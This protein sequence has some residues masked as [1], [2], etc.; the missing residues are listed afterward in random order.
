MQTSKNYRLSFIIIFVII[1]V[2]NVTLHAQ[3]TIGS[4]VPP[5]DSALLDLKEN[6]IGTSTKGLLLPRVELV[7]LNDNTP[8]SAHVRGMLVYNT[9]DVDTDIFEGCYYNDGTQ[10]IRVGA[11]AGSITI[12]DV[13]LTDLWQAPSGSG[14]DITKQEFR[15][16]GKAVNFIIKLERTGA[17]INVW[18]TAHNF[19]KI[20]EIPTGTNKDTYKPF[21][22]TAVTSEGNMNI[23]CLV[24]FPERS[25]STMAECE[26]DFE[27]NIYI[28]NVRESI[29][30]FMNKGTIATNDVIVV[31][32]SYFIK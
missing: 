31:S 22:S 25:I 3:V 20:A 17:D 26:I 1:L 7:A 10:W 4:D 14:W 27:G 21:A 5:D 23:S 32:G 9:A 29:G 18:N 15:G 6:S 13:G 12:P 24:N 19:Q 28:Q 8:L 16:Y 2:G 30:T 11:G